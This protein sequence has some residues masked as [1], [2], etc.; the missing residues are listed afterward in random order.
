MREAIVSLKFDARRE[1]RVNLLKLPYFQSY[2]IKASYLFHRHFNSALLNFLVN[3]YCK[4]TCSYARKKLHDY[5]SW[6]SFIF[7]YF[8]PLLIVVYAQL[9]TSRRYSNKPMLT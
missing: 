3:I 8:L 2:A 4:Q 1:K 5:I 6:H 7:I 9:C